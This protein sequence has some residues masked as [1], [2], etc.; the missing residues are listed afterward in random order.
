[1]VVH[2]LI[3]RLDVAQD[4]RPLSS[5]EA[6]LRC[7]FKEAYLGLASLGR[8]IARERSRFV[9]LK[10]GDTSSSFFRI[11]ASNCQIFSLKVG[12]HTVSEHGA[13]AQA[14]FNHFSGI[15]DSSEDRAF[16]LSLDGLYPDHFDPGSLDEP[17]SEDKILRA[18]KA[19]PADKALGPDG[20]TS[21]FLRSRWD[22]TK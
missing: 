5:S 7:R 1:M 20:F 18:I 16:S 4:L 19:M 11:H 15:L 13:L 10:Y 21:E 17:F 3:A 2:E 14:A 6:W 8:S 9:Y 22:I 12:D